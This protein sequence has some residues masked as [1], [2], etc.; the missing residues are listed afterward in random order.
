MTKPSGP[1]SGD[2]PWEDATQHDDSAQMDGDEQPTMRANDEQRA[3]LRA[4][5]A[6]A[7]GSAPPP[8]TSDDQRTNVRARSAT[9]PGA[10]SSTRGPATKTPPSGVQSDASSGSSSGSSPG[11]SSGSS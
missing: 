10:A 4:K 3:A 5:A 1:G 11:S 9:T 7:K 6:G 8:A 2:G